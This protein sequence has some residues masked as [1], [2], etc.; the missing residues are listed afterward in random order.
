MSRARLRGKI[1]DCPRA[2]PFALS[3]RRRACHASAA[4]FRLAAPFVDSVLFRA[5]LP[6]TARHFRPTSATRSLSTAPV[7]WTLEPRPGSRPGCSRGSPHHGGETRG[8]GPSGG[9][10]AVCPM[11]PRCSSPPAPLSQSRARAPASQPDAPASRNRR[12]PLREHAVTQC[13][14]H[15]IRDAFHWDFFERPPPFGRGSA[16]RR[17]PSR[18][19]LT[20]AGYAC[21]VRGDLFRCVG[22]ALT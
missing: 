19:P 2:Y 12:D 10:R 1:P 20:F 18:N 17:G 7:L 4:S 6:G 21:E 5:R 14:L 13:S 15:R 9:H 11:A 22:L 8:A 3:P 16:F